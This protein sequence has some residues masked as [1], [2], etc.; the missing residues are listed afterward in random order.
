MCYII[1]FCELT[2]TL[3]FYH[4]IILGIQLNYTKLR[5]VTSYLT[6]LVLCVSDQFS[7]VYTVSCYKVL[8]LELNV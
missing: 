1:T 6:P 2:G 4:V 7:T 8:E 5:I 3:I